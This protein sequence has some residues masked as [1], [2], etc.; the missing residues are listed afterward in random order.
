MAGG[1]GSSPAGD[2]AGRRASGRR[3]PRPSRWLGCR[4]WRRVVGRR[5]GGLGVVLGAAGSR[6]GVT[7]PAYPLARAQ[8]LAAGPLAVYTGAA[9]RRAGQRAAGMFLSAA[10]GTA[11]PGPCCRFGSGPLAVGGDG[12]LERRGA[13]GARRAGSAGRS[14]VGGD[15]GPIGTDRGPG[16]RLG[17]AVI[18]RSRQLDRGL[19]PAGAGGRFGAG[20]AMVRGHA[21]RTGG[22]R[23]GD[24]RRAAVRGGRGRVGIRPRSSPR[25]PDETFSLID[26]SLDRFAHRRSGG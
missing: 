24:G 12:P 10:V 23:G 13:C 25:Y 8:L 7:L 1:A 16:D 15:G 14:R 11:C 26:P 6:G 4:D 18:G 3:G 21:R 19:G 5:R 9:H 22:H 2:P 20:S 17:R